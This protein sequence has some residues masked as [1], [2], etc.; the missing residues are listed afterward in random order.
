MVAIATPA[1]G[2]LRSPA[3]KGIDYDTLG[4]NMCLGMKNPVSGETGRVEIG[5]LFERAAGV[6]QDRAGLVSPPGGNTDVGKGMAWLED[7][8]ASVRGEPGF[9]REFIDE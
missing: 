5:S 7:I 2:T 8:F 9:G 1:I 4:T 6:V 3:E